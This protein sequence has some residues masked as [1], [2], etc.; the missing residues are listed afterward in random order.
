MK[1]LQLLFSVV[2]LVSPDDPEFWMQ[3]SALM[4]TSPKMIHSVKPVKDIQFFG[5]STNS[6]HNPQ[7]EGRGL[8]H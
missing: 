3:L 4:L 8:V 7:E 1:L 5:S 2:V 6:S